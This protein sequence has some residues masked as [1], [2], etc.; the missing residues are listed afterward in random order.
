MKIL[1][2]LTFI[3]SSLVVKAEDVFK[4]EFEQNITIRVSQLEVVD[5]HFFTV[6]FGLFCGDIT[7]ELNTQIQTSISSDGDS[8]TFLDSNFIT[9]FSTDQPAYITSRN[10]EAAFI[11]GNCPAPL[12]SAACEEIT[13]LSANIATSF[14]ATESC[15]QAIPDTTSNYNPAPNVSIA[16]CYSTSAVTATMSIAG[17]DIQFQDYQ[18][19][20][21]YFEDL[22]LDNGLRRGFISEDDAETIII[23]ASVPVVGGQSLASLLPGGM[24]NCSNGDDRDLFT[25]GKTTG[26]WFYFNTTSE[27]IEMN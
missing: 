12:H 24:G 23:P 7:S 27:L 16:P 13:T 2:A 6:V 3:V 8:D 26:W 18:Q 15:M 4:N 5:P 10:L 21:R 14:D 17:I 9:Q 19:G 20:A 1:V 11:D 25:D 22:T